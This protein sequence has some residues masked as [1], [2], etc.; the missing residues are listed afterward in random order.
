MLHKLKLISAVI[1]LCASLSACMNTKNADHYLANQ[2]QMP[3]HGLVL[4]RGLSFE[5]SSELKTFLQD[6]DGYKKNNLHSGLE[7]THHPVGSKNFSF[8]ELTQPTYNEKWMVY[9]NET[10]MAPKD[11]DQLYRK[12]MHNPRKKNLWKYESPNLKAI[13]YYDIFPQKEGKYCLSRI[14]KGARYIE[15]NP[16]KECLGYSVKAG[17]VTYIGDLFTLTGK[18]HYGFFDGEWWDVDIIVKDLSD[19]AKKF[20]AQFEPK[21]NLPF[22]VD[23][24]KEIPNTK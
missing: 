12:F 10:S 17:H 9:K 4:F 20:I 22:R 19:D 5:E 1:V 23:L 21:I 2:E 6:R 11:L 24:I 14:L 7:F 16:D 8:L 13:Y 18:R 15:L 3:D